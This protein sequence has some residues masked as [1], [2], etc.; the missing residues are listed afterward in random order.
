[1]RGWQQAIPMNLEE[2]GAR[3]EG[4][5][6][7]RS[8]NAENDDGKHH[9]KLFRHSERIKSEEVEPSWRRHMTDDNS[10]LRRTLKDLGIAPVKKKSQVRSWKKTCGLGPTRKKHH[11]K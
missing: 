7:P 10:F 6:L 3:Y 2:N 1:M 11:W 4:K 8:T 9:Q 5:I